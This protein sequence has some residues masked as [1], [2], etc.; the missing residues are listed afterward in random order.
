VNDVKYFIE[1]NFIEE[2]FI[3]EYFLVS[4]EVRRRPTSLR[5]G[6]LNG[7]ITEAEL[8]HMAYA[9]KAKL[10]KIKETR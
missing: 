7:V 5:P 10:Y 8:G 1:E 4:P 2:N 3:E 9:R 6:I